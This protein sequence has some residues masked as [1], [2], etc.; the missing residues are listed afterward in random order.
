MHCIEIIPETSMSTCMG[1]LEWFLMEYLSNFG[2]DLTVEHLDLS[3]EGV[4]GW[5]MKIGPCEYVIQI[6]QDL[7]G[8]EYTKTLLHE[9]YH[10]Y[11]HLN[12]MPQ[13]EMCAYMSEDQNLD[14]LVNH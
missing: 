6:H 3:D 10:V 9:M 13:C 12:G 7:I 2:I 1:T 14:K 11:Q 4:T 5:C 8:D